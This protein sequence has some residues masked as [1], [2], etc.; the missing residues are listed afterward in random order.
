MAAKKVLT[1]ADPA[2][3][4]LMDPFDESFIQKRLLN[5]DKPYHEK[6]NKQITSVAPE[7]YRQRLLE[8]FGD[9]TFEVIPESIVEGKTGVRAAFQFSA[10][11][12]HK[13]AVAVFEPW[14]FAGEFVYNKDSGKFDKPNPKAGQIIQPE[15]TYAMLDSAAIKA[16]SRNLGLGLHLYLDKADN[17]APSTSATTASAAHTQTATSNA[18]PTGGAY[19]PEWTGED[20]ITFGKHS[21]KKWNHPD[22]DA[23]YLNYITKDPEKANKLGLKEIAR[24]LHASAGSAAQNAAAS[25]DEDSEIPF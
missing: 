20:E 21:G 7:H 19:D 24:R 6:Y 12:L 5:P 1:S 3:Q 23:G 13:R 18:A 10:K 2:I 9:F 25:V 14:T 11:G 8:V 17:A 15:Y 4:R 22:V 16:I